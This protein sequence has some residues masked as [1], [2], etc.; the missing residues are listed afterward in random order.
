MTHYTKLLVA[1][2]GLAVAFATA[3][4]AARPTSMNGRVVGDKDAMSGFYTSITRDKSGF[5]WAGT[6][7]GLLR[8]DGSSIDTY[9]H[10]NTDPGSVSD[11]R[12]M[13][14]LTDSKGRLW[15]GTSNGLNLYDPSTGSFTMI[16]LPDVD[17]P[18]YIIDITEDYDNNVVFVVSGV[19]MYVIADTGEGAAP[20]AVRYMLNLPNEK[21]FNTL[22][23]TRDGLL[24][25]G[26]HN[27][28]LVT[29]RPN[30]QAQTV[31][32]S[33]T[34]IV[35]LIVDSDSTIV[36]VTPSTVLRW[37]PSS[38]EFRPISIDSPV[39]PYFRAGARRAD[40]SILLST[41]GSGLFTLAPGDDTIHPYG[42]IQNAAFDINS[43]TR[44]SSV[45]SDPDGN[46]WLGCDYL[47]IVLVPAQK[48]AFQ[49]L[50]IGELL[51]NYRGGITAVAYDSDGLL[52]VA[53]EV[54]GLICFDESN[55]PIIH[56][57]AP[58]D[59]TSLHLSPVDSKLYAGVSN[60]GLYQVDVAGRRLKLLR[61]VDGNFVV[62]GMASDSHGDIY[63]AI[64]GQGVLRHSPTTGK[65]RLITHTEAPD[66]IPNDWVS[67]LHVDH[68]DRLWIGYFSGVGLYDCGGD[69]LIAVDSSLPDFRQGVV[70]SITSTPD[71]I[72][73]F[74]TNIGLKR[75][76]LSN[77]ATTVLTT[78]HGLADNT[79]TGIFRDVNGY[80]WLSTMRGLS[81]LDP[82]TLTIKSFFSGNGLN[83]ITY[84]HG[85]VDPTGHRFAMTGNSGVTLFGPEAAY[86]RAMTRPP[87]VSA[88]HLI[89]RS[90]YPSTLSGGQP[91]IVGDPL[92]PDALQLSYR[93]NTLA[94]R[95]T[96]LDYR[97]PDNVGYEWRLD[98]GAWMSVPPGEKFIRLTNLSPDDYNFEVRAVENG[99]ASPSRLIRLTVTPP[100]YMTIAAKGVYLL[101]VIILAALVVEAIRKKTSE[102]INDEK[103]K[104]FMNIS[105]EL[106]SPLT[107]VLG[108]LESMLREPHDPVTTS[109]LQI[110][111][112]NARRMLNLINQLLDIRKID[113]GKMKLH[114]TP[115]EMKPFVTEMVDLFRPQAESK[116]IILECRGTDVTAWIDPINFDKVLANLLSNAIKFTPEGGKVEVTVG[117][118][119]DNRLGDCMEITVADTGPGMDEKTIE[120]L[121]ERFYQGSGKGNLGVGFG[122][123]LDLTRM[124]VELHHGTITGANRSDV[125]GSIFYVRIP[126][127]NAHLLPEEMKEEQHVTV[128]PAERLTTPVNTPPLLTPQRKERTSTGLRMLVVDDDADIR[129]YLAGHFGNSWKVTVAADGDQALRE[130]SAKPYDLII[131]DVVMPGTDGFTLLKTVKGNVDTNHI[132]II[133]LST[134]TDAESRMEGWERGAD[135]YLGKPFNVEELD[136]IVESLIGN[137]RLLKGKF[138]GAQP[139]T[140]KIPVADLKGNDQQLV[141]KIMRIV[142]EHIDDPHLNVEK[143][144]E[145]VGISRAHLHRKMK[146]LTGLSPSDYI[147]NARLKY[148]CELLKNPDIDITQIAYTVGFASQPHFSTAFKRF[149]GMS[150][151]DY[152]KNG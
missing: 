146:E 47:G 91:V 116:N 140:D 68:N 42:P 31:H 95:M 121:F 83:D 23:P 117:P 130:L 77:G 76:D 9:L 40:S 143:L 72:L 122:I 6:E 14:L 49:Y 60:H 25:A 57:E 105:H 53:S 93:D 141:E 13:K 69:S 102:R 63:A 136:A 90:V 89:D 139:T 137:R 7:Y 133:L 88:V 115:M 104:F 39:P 82:E 97:D 16:D 74:G 11:S 15:V 148:A 124:V 125:R 107:L 147:R 64:H 112:R 98:N 58:D 65:G 131:S 1:I 99:I 36:A 8:F 38:G 80:L 35:S 127:G 18:G 84:R 87:L 43:N 123:G 45:Y 142:N 110:M 119:T 20:S 114:C 29:I 33:D 56:I 5:T 132:P 19:G 94:L 134:K 61:P 71:G 48:E 67:A 145:E 92:A 100:W 46:L 101:V 126:L 28:D 79:V 86:S 34:Y 41:N 62:T 52:W 12:I 120:H 128:L 96:T 111:H 50:R 70:R 108:P 4:A 152:R 75:V 144:G 66:L 55:K 149:T 78:N 37:N 113:K 118:V 81:R 85:A 44:I 2:L 51:N 30:G 10:D 22:V 106:R 73:W 150:P 17:F 59:I 138:T 109:R 21:S 27:G 24:V 32:V 3:N 135:G 54:Q 129:S 151:T 103:I 26:T